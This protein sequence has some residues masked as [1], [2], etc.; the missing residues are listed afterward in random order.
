[1]ICEW[2][3]GRQGVAYERVFVYDFAAP[4]RQCWN[5]LVIFTDNTLLCEGEPGQ[6]LTWSAL[7]RVRIQHVD[8]D[9]ILDLRIEG[10]ERSG[11]PSSQFQA[12]CQKLL[13]RESAPTQAEIE[14]ERALLGPLKQ[15]VHDFISDGA[16]FRPPGPP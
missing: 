3:D 14:A 5:D 12:A 9:G 16:H 7:D 4:D 13:N 1:L 2:A 10:R 15:L 6:P 11:L 8:R